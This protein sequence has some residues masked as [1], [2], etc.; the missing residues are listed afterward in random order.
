MSSNNW[1]SGKTQIFWTCKAL[2]DGR[3]ISHKTEIREVRG[4]RLGSII[5]RLK[6]ELH[7]PIL[8]EYRGPDNIAHYW[9]SKDA[10]VSE[11]RF[12]QSAKAL[13]VK[14]DAAQ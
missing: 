5:H 2:I 11:L 7:W 1:H 3:T 4:W 12:P 6:A 8:V 14:G 9:L 10:I 13:G